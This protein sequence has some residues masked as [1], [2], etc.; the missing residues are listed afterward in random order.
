MVE[1]RRHGTAASLRLLIGGLLDLVYP[2]RCLVC[3]QYD[4]P[5]LCENCA[6]AFTAIPEPL[7]QICGR[8]MEPEMKGVCRTCEAH[9]Q[10]SGKDWAFD[11]ARSAGIF[12]GSLRHAVHQLKYNGGE[13]LG[14]ALG[15]YLANCLGGFELFTKEQM[16]TIDGVLAVPMHPVRERNRGFNQAAL[17]AAPVAEML[18]VPLL[19]STTVRRSRRPAQVG[20]S[21]TARR[22]NLTNAFVVSP[23]EVLRL[24]GR[25]ILVIDDVFTTGTTVNA[26]AAALRDAGANRILIATLAGGG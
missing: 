20:L 11:G 15:A 17:L 13:S 21:S 23:E 26:C 14:P 12:E 6:A 1:G 10:E 3:E 25:Q 19:S 24:Q 9:R 5:S 7:C 18:G 16:G 8:P 2:P 22:R 4:T